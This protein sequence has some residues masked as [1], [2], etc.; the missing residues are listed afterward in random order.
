MAGI[1][2]QD[3]SEVLQVD[4]AQGEVVLDEERVGQP[5]AADG[6]VIQRS[7]TSQN[8]RGQKELQPDGERFR[9]QQRLAIHKRACQQN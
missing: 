6:V 5:L 9:G 1:A 8:E 2:C 4:V 7:R 3:V